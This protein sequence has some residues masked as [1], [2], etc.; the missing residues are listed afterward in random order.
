MV[1]GVGY[2][3]FLGTRFLVAGCS[4]K[5]ENNLDFVTSL[6]IFVNDQDVYV[7]GI[8]IINECA[9][10]QVA[11]GKIK[12]L[13]KIKFTK[14]FSSQECSTLPQ[15]GRI[16]KLY[17]SN[18]ILVST[19]ADI[20]KRKDEYD[21]KPQ[22]EKSIFGKILKINL[23][24]NSY[25]IFSKGHRNILGL[26][27]DEKV[28]LATENGP[29]G[30]D[31]INNIKSNYNYGWPIA[32][33]GQKYKSTEQNKDLDY[34]DN[35]ASH[36]FEEPIYSF[37]PSIGISEIIKLENT[38]SNKWKDNYLVGSLNGNHIYRLK[39]DNNFNKIIYMEKI[40]IG[41]RIRDLMFFKNRNLILLALESYGNLGVIK[42]F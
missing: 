8:K 3:V 38:F 25:S 28:I 18:S 32:S 27:S 23:D 40:F 10:F 12:N 1:A 33:Y 5:I 20:L 22:D 17:G 14:I 24:D 39:F 21:P 13:N 4:Q 42:K 36:G 26:Y 2:V 16:Q 15:A 9:H 19:G 11:K 41:E 29:K 30:G 6:D 37:V 7:S 35:H 31:E 34:K